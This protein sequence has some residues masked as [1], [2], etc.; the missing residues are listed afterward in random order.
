MLS[1]R[2]PAFLKIYE[3][4]FVASFVKCEA[5][6]CE[7]LDQAKG[8]AITNGK[9]NNEQFAASHS[10]KHRLDETTRGMSYIPL[11]VCLA[12]QQQVE[13]K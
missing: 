11:G 12:S 9:L 3:I 7:I 2:W 6:C 5:C 10:A 4:A 1:V 13:C 8:S